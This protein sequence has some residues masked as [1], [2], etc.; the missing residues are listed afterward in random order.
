MCPTP[1]RLN[2]QHSMQSTD[3]TL[4][5]YEKVCFAC[6]PSFLCWA[7]YADCTRH[8]ELHWILQST[9]FRSMLTSSA[10]H[11]RKHPHID[12][13]TR[14]NKR[15]RRYEDQTGVLHLGLFKPR[16]CDADQP[17]GDDGQLQ[18]PE[19][20][21]KHIVHVRRHGKQ[22]RQKPCDS[23]GNWLTHWTSHMGLTN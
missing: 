1:P 23:A 14:P 19:V 4:P 5:K 16:E 9:F 22:P 2:R 21:F 3:T 6:R 17:A 10:Y 20:P 15:S 13:A 12:S 7:P 18:V 8:Q 11:G